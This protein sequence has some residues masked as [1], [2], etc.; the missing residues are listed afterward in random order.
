MS[1]NKTFE[2]K[3][4]VREIK[5]FFK[6]EQLTG[7]DESLNRWVVVPDVNRPGF[8]LMGYVKPTSPRR[9]IIM[10]HK[11]IEFI[12]TLTDEQQRERYHPI[13]DPLTPM[14][15]LTH[16]NEIPPVLKEVADS[17]N[18]PIFRTPNDTF[19]M[20]VDLVTYLDE[21][22][23]EET[24][25]SGVLMSVY[26][27]GVLLTGESGMGK[28]ETALELIRDGQVLIADDRVD[29]Q[30]IHNTIVGHAPDLLKGMLELRG[31]GIVDVSR[32][33]GANCLMDRHNVDMVINLVKYDP[34]DEYERLGEVSARFTRIMDVL[35]PT[36][37]LPVSTGRSMRI[38]IESA[39]TNFILKEEGYNAS[40][41]FKDRLYQY[42]ENADR[43][44]SK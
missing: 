16:N 17:Q 30:K 18:F 9:I 5:E 38:L 13:T 33:Y 1:E 10:G 20:F 36:I 31:I 3:V 32:M 44:N 15:V 34:H 43:E 27:K 12:H 25:M 8:E 37:V 19:R 42:L 7:N 28:S 22:L 2:K 35:I 14:M 21:K 24:T 4:L 26:G 29:L 11:E 23:A 6:F 39:V 40:T 41:N